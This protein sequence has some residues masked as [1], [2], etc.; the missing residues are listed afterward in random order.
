MHILLIEDSATDTLLVLNALERIPGCEVVAVKRLSEALDKLKETSF[1]VVLTDLGLPDSYGME[2][3]HSL[4]P[5]CGEAAVVVMTV[6]NSPN[7]GL[8][9]LRTGSQD[10]LDKVHLTNPEAIRRCLVYARER[11]KHVSEIMSLERELEA[12]RKRKSASE[13]SAFWGQLATEFRQAIS[14]GKASITPPTELSP[15]KF[16]ELSKAYSDVLKRSVDMRFSNNHSDVAPAVSFLA[17]NLGQVGANPRDVVGIHVKG[18]RMALDDPQNSSRTQLFVEESRFRL[19]ELMGYLAM[20]YR[21]NKPP[22]SKG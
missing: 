17:R 4:Y 22:A 20:Y 16:D 12:A 6:D 21:D 11:R 13:E 8:A 9:A 18:L 19:V 3:L 2:T 1:D 7:Q 5:H 15:K 14:G 10:Y